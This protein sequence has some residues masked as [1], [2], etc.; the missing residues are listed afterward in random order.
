MMKKCKCGNT[1]GLARQRDGIDHCPACDPPW[2]H[3]ELD[4]LIYGI[5]YDMTGKLD[6]HDVMRR[7]LEL[8]K[9]IRENIV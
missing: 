6:C 1:L 7:V 3:K 8:T 9:L 2:I 5:E 4:D